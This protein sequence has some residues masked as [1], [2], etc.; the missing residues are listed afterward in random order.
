[1]QTSPVTTLSGE[2]IAVTH[3]ANSCRITIELKGTPADTAS[4][5]K[6][7]VVQLGFLEGQPV[8][9]RVGGEQVLVGVCGNR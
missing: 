3:S 1:M 6:Q 5:M 9:A 8:S 4:L 7:S 2:V